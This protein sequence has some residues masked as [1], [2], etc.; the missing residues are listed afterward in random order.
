MASTSPTDLFLALDT[1]F[2][3][4]SVG[5]FKKDKRKTPVSRNTG[6]PQ[7]IETLAF[8]EWIIQ[9][10]GGKSPL[11]SHSERLIPEIV[12]LL[13]ETGKS[14]S[15]LD[16]LAVS[17]GPGRFTGVRTTV[18]TARALAFSLQI[19][20]YPLN[21]LRITAESFLQSSSP[22]IVAFNAFKNSI[23]FAEFSSAG[24][25]LS[26]PCVLSFPRYLEKIKDKN[27][28]L[29]DVPRFYNLP[30]SLKKSCEF[31]EAFPSTRSLAQ[32][33]GREFHSKNL[34]PWF[35]LQPLYLR[36]IPH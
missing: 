18:N 2:D 7:K 13:N 27:Q 9:L 29:G 25:E 4:G 19:P 33:I 28:C 31:K 30:E 36:T 32:V 5:L 1:S 3:K 24:K 20:C 15:Q 34:L 10:K 35:Q 6:I 23:Y 16:F 17:I 12:S 8:R 21:S 14:L 11:I 26:S 22:V